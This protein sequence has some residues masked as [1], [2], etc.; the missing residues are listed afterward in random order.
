MKRKQTAFF[1]GKTGIYWLMVCPA[2]IW[3]FF[4][5]I[6]PMFGI[7]MAFQDFS[8]NRGFFRSDWVGFQSGQRDSSIGICRSGKLP[9]YV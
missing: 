3:M 5:N 7:I 2:L 8:P 1:K 9:L 4:I 6:V